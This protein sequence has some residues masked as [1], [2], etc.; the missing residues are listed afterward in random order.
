MWDPPTRVVQSSGASLPPCTGVSSPKPGCCPGQGVWET[1]CPQLLPISVQRVGGGPGTKGGIRH[2][3]G[4]GE[5]ETGRDSAGLFQSVHTRG[6]PDRKTVGRRM[7]PLRKVPSSPQV[8]PEMLTPPEGPCHQ[9][10]GVGAQISIIEKLQ[11]N[12]G[13]S[14]LSAEGTGVSGEFFVFLCVPSDK[15]VGSELGGL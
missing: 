1:Q 2:P 5:C 7:L 13:Y 4:G 6:L 14:S 11:M 8:S 15:S 3:W 12:K 9:G 10:C